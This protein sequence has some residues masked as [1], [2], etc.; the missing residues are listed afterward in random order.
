MGP[1][2]PQAYVNY[3]AAQLTT[4]MAGQN[5]GAIGTLE[6]MATKWGIYPDPELGVLLYDCDFT[7]IRCGDNWCEWNVTYEVRNFQDVPYNYTVTL[8]ADGVT[9][10]LNSGTLGATF[11]E[12]GRETITKTVVVNCDNTDAGCGATMYLAVTSK[13]VG[14]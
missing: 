10:E 14:E 4:C 2:S 3:F 11:S 8:I 12:I 1:V 6:R 5:H 13:P 9:R 7:E